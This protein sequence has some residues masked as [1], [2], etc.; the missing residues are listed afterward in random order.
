MAVTPGD[1]LLAP[2][3]E[4]ETYMML[5]L[6]LGAVGALSRRRARSLGSLPV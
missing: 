1:V 3:P 5:L 6:G 2:V 4:P